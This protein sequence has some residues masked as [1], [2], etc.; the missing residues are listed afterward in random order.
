MNFKET[1]DKNGLTEKEAIEFFRKKNYPKPALTADIAV[2]AKQDATLRLL[3]IRRG[4]H[5]FL[6]CWALPGGFADEGE[7]IEQTAARELEEETG[8]KGLSLSLVGV[9]SEPGR[10]PRGWTVSAAYTVLLPDGV[11]QAE[12]GDDAADTAWVE[13]QFRNG[14]AEVLLPDKG[15]PAFDHGMIIADAIK[16]LQK[17]GLIREEA[18]ED[19]RNTQ[20]PGYTFFWNDDEENGVFSNWYHSPFVVDDFVYQ[21]VEQYMMAQKAKVFHDAATFTKILK[22]DKPGKCKKLGRKVTPFDSG[23]WDAVRYE[24]V[25]AGNRAKYEQNPELKEALLKTGNSLLAEASP[26]DTIWGI[27]LDREAAI[28]TDPQNWP[29]Q[30]LMGKILTELR[31]EFRRS[32]V[33]FESS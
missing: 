29:G 11:I 12:A 6:G 23:K 15:Q 21:H 32:L 9:Y 14:E 19:D 8:I 33:L 4:G 16:C 18:R 28:Q 27:G 30:N 13:I 31:E 7:T 24:I 25:K 5:P 26:K 3:M 2:F 22:T 20:D 1:V 17:K 10:D